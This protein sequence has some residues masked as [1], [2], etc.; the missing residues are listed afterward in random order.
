M[1]VSNVSSGG[2]TISMGLKPNNE[3]IKHANRVTSK[4]VYQTKHNTYENKH[5]G[6]ETELKT[7]T[8]KPVFLPRF[9]FSSRQSFYPPLPVHL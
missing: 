6:T 7:N 1:G 8:T 4:S 5:Q 2:V 3:L 9:P